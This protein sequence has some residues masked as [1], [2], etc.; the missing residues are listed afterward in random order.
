[1]RVPLGGGTPQH[2]EDMLEAARLHKV[3]RDAW[4]SFFWHPP[5]IR[6]ELGLS[7][8]EKLVDGI[9]AQGYEF[10]SLAELRKRGD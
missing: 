4:A 2:I 3:V 5:L 6:T 7:S 10:V 1:V 8:L 9:R